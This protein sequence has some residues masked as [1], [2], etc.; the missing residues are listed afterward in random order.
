MS[1]HRCDNVNAVSLYTL[2]KGSPC[3]WTPIHERRLA[4]QIQRREDPLDELEGEV[5]LWFIAPHVPAIIHERRTLT[6]IAPG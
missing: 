3:R 1:E 6:L 5:P 4:W 2:S